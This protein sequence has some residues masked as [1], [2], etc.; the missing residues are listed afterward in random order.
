M[1]IIKGKTPTV[2]KG[3]K[4]MKKAQFIISAIFTVLCVASCFFANCFVVDA[5]IIRSGNP[6]LEAIAL[7]VTIPLSIISYVVQLITGAVAFGCAVPCWKSE[8]KSIK[9]VSIVFSSVLGFTLL[10]SAALFLCLV[11][12]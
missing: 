2:Y 12:L 4:I 9:V 5:L 3:G 7:I 11:L 10:V 1:R 6:G 8:S